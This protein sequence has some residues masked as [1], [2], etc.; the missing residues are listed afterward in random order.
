MKAYRET[1]ETLYDT[2]ATK[3]TLSRYDVPHTL[4]IYARIGLFFTSL[5]LLFLLTK[6]KFYSIENYNNHKPCS[7]PK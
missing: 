4:F 6:R 5:P 2:K 7:Q 1:L 3:K